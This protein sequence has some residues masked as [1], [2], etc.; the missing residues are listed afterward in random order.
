MRVMGQWALGVCVALVIIGVPTAYYR[1]AY[2]NQKRLRVVSD[3]KFYRSGQLTASGLRDAL[4]EFGIRTVINLQEENVDP[5]MPEVWLGK[6]S[7]RESELCEQLGVN[8]YALIGGETIADAQFQAGARPQ[9]IDQYLKL[10]DDPKNYP[11][12]IHCKAGLHRTGLLTAVYRMEY[13]DWPT[14]RAVDELRAN[15]FGTYAA[16]TGNVY[17]EQFLASYQKG[18]RH[19]VPMPTEGTPKV[20]EGPR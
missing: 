20:A 13:C 14:R 19:P 10:L 7:V 4:R 11:I 18:Q 8:Y 17:L 2:S 16:T 5:F 15:G 3:G 6:P 9:V 1:S 12:I